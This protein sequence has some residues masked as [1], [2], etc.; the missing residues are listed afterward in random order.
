MATHAGTCLH[1]RARALT[2]VLITSHTF[3]CQHVCLVS[4][5]RRYCVLGVKRVKRVKRVE[6]VDNMYCVL[7]SS[8]RMLCVV[9]CVCVECVGV[10]CGVCMCVQGRRNRGGGGGGGKGARPPLPFVR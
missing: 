6:C 3:Q 5:L 1:T 4:S 8:F 10:V 9:V 2:C 7:N